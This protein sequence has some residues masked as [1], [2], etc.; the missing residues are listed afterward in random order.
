MEET[1]VWVCWK[2]CNLDG[3]FLLL[4]PVAH[5]GLDFKKV[6]SDLFHFGRE[7]MYQEKNKTIGIVPKQNNSLKTF[8]YAIQKHLVMHQSDITCKYPV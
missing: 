8:P 4:S 1:K 3:K 2:I 7:L 6:V 5:I